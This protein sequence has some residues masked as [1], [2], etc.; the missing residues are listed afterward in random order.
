MQRATTKLRALVRAGKFLELP[1]AYD[2]ITARLAQETGFKTVYSGGFVTG[3]SSCISEPLLTMNEQIRVASDMANAV[4]IPVVMDAG[5][6]WGHVVFTS[7]RTGSR[8]LFVLDTESGRARQLTRGAAARLAAWSP[9][10][11]AAP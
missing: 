3:G 4:D 7:T 5:A 11:G 1:S 8:Q 10:L 2:P 6:G 9:Y